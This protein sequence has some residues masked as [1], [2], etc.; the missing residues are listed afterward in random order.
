MKITGG[1][2]GD[3][4]QPALAGSD[5]D[6]TT[7]PLDLRTTFE[8]VSVRPLGE[9]RLG[10]KKEHQCMGAPAEISALAPKSFWPKSC[11]SVLLNCSRQDKRNE[12]S[13]SDGGAAGFSYTRGPVGP[14]G[15][16]GPPGAKCTPEQLEWVMAQVARAAPSGRLPVASTVLFVIWRLLGGALVAYL[17]LHLLGLWR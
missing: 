8:Q 14:T 13:T 2:R 15:P 9:V 1:M 4:A 12:S 6:V 16:V 17:L 3:I 11:Q 7:N 5:Q 10:V